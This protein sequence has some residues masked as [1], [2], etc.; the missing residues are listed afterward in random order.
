MQEFPCFIEEI[1]SRCKKKIV[2]LLLFFSALSLIT[3]CASYKKMI[4]PELFPKQ[5]QFDQSGLDL[6]RLNSEKEELNTATQQIVNDIQNDWAETRAVRAVEINKLFENLKKQSEID[7]AFQTISD[8]PATELMSEAGWEMLMRSAGFYSNVYQKN[9]S[10]RRIINRGDVANDIPPKTLLQ[11]Q[12]FLWDRRNQKRLERNQVQLSLNNANRRVFENEKQWDNLFNATYKIMRF[13]SELIS[14]TISLDRG[15]PLPESNIIRLIPLLKK[16]DIVC[17][18]SPRRFTDKFIP[19]YFGHSGIYLGDNLFA[20]VIQSGSV[21]ASP[22]KFLEGDE[23]IVLRPK[24]ITESQNDKMI[25]NL[26]SQMGKKYDFN[27]N[28]ESPDRLFCTE[29]IYLVYDHIAWETKKIAGRNT[30]LPDY[31]VKTALVNNEL[32]LE[33]FM[34]NAEIIKKPERIFVEKLLKKK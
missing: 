32:E 8:L 26:K 21:Y 6:E 34:N 17:Q 33:Y 28:V 25:N 10:L 12:K 14:R 1:I 31:L 13:G 18:K 22:H 27:F 2:T 30:L 3:S 7:L 29:L 16:W 20:E 9:K 24:T 15:K 23:F 4:V 19:G 5:A 11:S